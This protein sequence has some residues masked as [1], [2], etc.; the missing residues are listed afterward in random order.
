MKNTI[1]G[2]LEYETSIVPLEVRVN[3]GDPTRIGNVAIN[4][5][6]VAR[7][8]EPT[9]D[10]KEDSASEKDDHYQKIL[11]K[12]YHSGVSHEQREK[13]RKLLK[14]ESLVFTVENDDMGNVT[15]HKMGINLSENTPVQ[16]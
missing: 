2:N 12:I 15:T 6:E 4:K 16:Q 14:E 3:T 7:A 8:N 13:F 1:I 11:E 10:S 9:T 5:T